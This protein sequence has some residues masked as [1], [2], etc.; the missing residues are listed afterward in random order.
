MD[1]VIIWMKPETKRGPA[2]VH[3]TKHGDVWFMEAVSKITR[4]TT[5]PHVLNFLLARNVH[6]PP[7]EVFVDGSVLLG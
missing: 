3:W 4:K 5:Y 6:D 2:E 7:V 1:F